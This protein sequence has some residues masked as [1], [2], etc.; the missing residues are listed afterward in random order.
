VFQQI[1]MARCDN[2][3][4]R[5]AFSRCRTSL[6]NPAGLLI[7]RSLLPFVRLSSPVFSRRRMIRCLDSTGRGFGSCE[8]FG[9]RVRAKG[10]P[11][12]ARWAGGRP[13]GQKT[14]QIA[15]N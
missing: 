11:Y 3:C 9:A 6:T 10:R 1:C 5:F 4:H 2:I 13:F 12:S 7:T 14:L 15:A 8:Y